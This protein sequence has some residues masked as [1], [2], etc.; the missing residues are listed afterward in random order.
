MTTEIKTKIFAPQLFT[1]TIA[2][3]ANGLARQSI[4]ITNPEKYPA[5]L[6]SICIKSGT[7]APIAGTT[8]AIYLLRG[9]GIIRD[10]GAGNLDAPII[11][12]N[13]SLLGTIVV[14][15]TVSKN[16]YGIFDT[17]PLGPLGSEWGIAIKNNSGQALDTVEANH[18][19]AFS[20]YI[21]ELVDVY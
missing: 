16:F 21:S 9:D 13:A 19:K 15:A 6:I 12:E 7:I 8:Y 20:Y 14:T 3:L 1:C 5:A 18:R 2:G 4:I 17:S 11:I 10:D